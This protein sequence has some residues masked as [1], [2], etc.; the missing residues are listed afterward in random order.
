M[1]TTTSTYGAIQTN[2]ITDEIKA[3]R[4]NITDT[5]ALSDK[6]LVRITRL[7]LVTDPGYP[8][9]DVSYCYGRLADGTDVRVR[10]RQLQFSKRNLNR[11]LIELFKSEGRYAKGMG[12]FDGETVSKMYG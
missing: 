12:I 8:M 6:R 1:P 3:M 2:G 4:D 11:E 7:R 10:F 5:V 9:W